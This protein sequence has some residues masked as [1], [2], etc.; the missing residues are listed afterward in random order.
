MVMEQAKLISSI[1]NSQ[2]FVAMKNR[3]MDIVFE[4]WKVPPKQL[5]QTDGASKG[6]PGY[7][8][9]GGIIRNDAGFWVTGFGINIG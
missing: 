2:K 1:W 6:N 4:K 8:C 5:V 3:R 9:G 7:A